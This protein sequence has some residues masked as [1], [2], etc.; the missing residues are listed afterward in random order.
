MENYL[1]R[2]KI[3]NVLSYYVREIKNKFLNIVLVRLGFFNLFKILANKRT[4]YRG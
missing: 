4:A 2:K 1:E 3:I